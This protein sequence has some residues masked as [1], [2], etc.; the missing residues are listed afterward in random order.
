MPRC[1]ANGP[2][3]LVVTV[4]YKRGVKTRYERPKQGL[5]V[6]GSGTSTGR[7]IPHVLEFRMVR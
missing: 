7:R 6:L 1:V 2:T 5:S 3:I 4:T